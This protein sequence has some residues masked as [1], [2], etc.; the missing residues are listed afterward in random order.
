TLPDGTRLRRDGG[1]DLESRMTPYTV[2]PGKDLALPGN[3][4]L[5]WT[6]DGKALVLHGQE[7]TGFY[8]GL[9]WS[10]EGLKPGKYLVSAEYTLA[11][12]PDPAQPAWVGKVRTPPVEFEVLNSRAGLNESK[13]V[14]ARG[15]DFQTVG[16]PQRPAPAPGGRQSIDL[17]FAI[18]N[19]TD[20][21]LVFNLYD[22]LWPVLKSAGGKPFECTKRRL[23]TAPA[24]PVLVA[25]GKVETVLYRAGLV[26]LPDGQTLRLFVP[27]VSGRTWYFPA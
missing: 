1:T 7:N 6:D 20:K 13:A 3:A 5:Q 21:T 14:R 23:R 4:F 8:C 10:F 19:P 2:E 18:T 27:D 12:S 11:N 15:V 22:T 9:Y 26:R 16:D 17:G 24:L 25:P